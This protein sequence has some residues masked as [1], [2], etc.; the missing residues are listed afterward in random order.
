MHSAFVL[1]AGFGTRLRPLTE[2]RPKP[3]VPVCGVPLIDFSLALCAKH[4][5]TQVL[6]NAHH[7][8]DQV[9]ALAGERE[10][11]RVTVVTELP[12]ILGTGGGLKAVRDQLDER[13]VVLNGDVLHEVD[14]AALR[15]AVPVGGGALAL[16]HDP[17]QAPV[18]GIVAMDATGTVVELRH[19]ASG[20]AEGPV[21]RTTHFTGIHAVHRDTLD[22]VPEGFACIVRTAYTQLVPERGVRGVRYVGPWLDTGDPRTYGQ[23]NLALLRGEV[24]PTLDPFL[25]AGYARRADGEVIGDA[26]LVAYARLSGPVWVGPGATV[27]AALLEESVV[28]PGATVSDGTT[29]RRCIVWD[30]TTVP[31][32]DHTDRVFAE[33]V[34]CALG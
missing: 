16:R 8:A 6:V 23:T 27:G 11:V 9:Q 33:G 3:L 32:G 31:P 12:D 29:L 19:Y 21:D 18:Y 26:E 2:L 28:G 7:L 22:R 5:L 25:R 30:D 17:E 1:A 34:T 15:A 24:R 20:P 4:G 10:G 13:F 14:L